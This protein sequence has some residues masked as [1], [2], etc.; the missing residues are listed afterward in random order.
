LEQKK[1]EE[2]KLVSDDTEVGTN[3]IEDVKENE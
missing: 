2:S 3:D 1:K